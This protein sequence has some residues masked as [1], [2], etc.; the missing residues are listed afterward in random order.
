MNDEKK[1]RQVKRFKTLMLVVAGFA[2]L[3]PLYQC[4][5]TLIRF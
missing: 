2:A 5:Q 1:Q 4:A 3:F